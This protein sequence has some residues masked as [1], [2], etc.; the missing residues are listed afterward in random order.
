MAW[1]PTKNTAGLQ[2]PAKAAVAG[3]ALHQNLQALVTHFHE[4]PGREEP[5]LGANQGIKKEGDQAFF[6]G[7]EES[8]L[9][10]N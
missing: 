3:A 7:C 4:Q 10:G 6:G 8:N 2:H 1:M 9:V 5:K